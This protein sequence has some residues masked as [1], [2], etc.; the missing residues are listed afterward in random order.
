MEVPLGFLQKEN[1]ADKLN[2]DGK[3]KNYNV[4]IHKKVSYYSLVGHFQDII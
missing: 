1:E 3:W 2:Q 4:I